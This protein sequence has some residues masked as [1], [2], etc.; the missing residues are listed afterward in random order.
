M[1]D[2]AS[3]VITIN[4]VAADLKLAAINGTGATFTLERGANGNA[5]LTPS[6]TGKQVLSKQT[7]A[8]DTF[9]F[10]AA[11]AF[12]AITWNATAAIFKGASTVGVQIQTNGNTTTPA[13][14][15]T[16]G[17]LS[18]FG[19]TTDSSNGRIQLATHTTSAG[20]I[21]FGTDSALYRVNASQLQL[22]QASATL[23][24]NSTG[25]NDS[26]LQISSAAQNWQIRRVNSTGAL[27]INDVTNGDTVMSFLPNGSIAI[28]PNGTT[29]LT[30]DSSQ[31][32]LKSTGSN[33]QSLNIKHLTELTTIAAAATTDT[34]ILMPAGAIV[35]SVSV[36]VT[37]VI[38][39]ATNFTVG[40]SGSAARFSTAAVSAAANSTDVGT[41]AGAYYNASALAVRITPDA[42]PAAN[43]G[44]VRVTI[45]YLDVTVPTA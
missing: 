7:D 30:L 33:G 3:N 1:S 24:I 43:T 29:A 41:K 44:R 45:A 15:C 20:G 17:Q 6:G 8:L 9:N 23:A 26:A 37:V 27:N 2:V 28:S 16:T 11:G 38:P 22:D 25:S 36:R 39:T 4:A 18:L 31:F 42:P 35:L 13:I 5:I 34:T 40:D 19:T 10:G 32:L 12:G 14:F 21:G